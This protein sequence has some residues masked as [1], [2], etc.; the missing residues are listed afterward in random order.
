MKK[1]QSLNLLNRISYLLNICFIAFFLS[2]FFKNNIKEE[3]KSGGKMVN[4]LQQDTFQKKFKVAIVLPT[5]ISA[6][7]TIKEN[8][9]NELNKSNN[10][11]FSFKEYYANN[12]TTLLKSSL[13]DIF[14]GSYDLIFTIGALC[15]RSAREAIKKKH[16]SIPIVFSGVSDAVVEELVVSFKTLIT[17]VKV[18]DV[19]YKDHVALLLQLKKNIKNVV[20][21][22]D[23]TLEGLESHKQ[24][25]QKE[26]ENHGI[27]VTGVPV[28]HTNE[29]VQKISPFLSSTD[30]VITLRDSVVLVGIEGLIKLCNQWGVTLCTSELESVDKGAALG[31]GTFYKDIGIAS[32]LQAK[33]ILIEKTDPKNIPIRS[34]ANTWKMRLNLTTMKQ[35]N[36]SIPKNLLFLMNNAQVI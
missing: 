29:V 14:I 3:N 4:S 6:L 19:R 18:G 32:G 12:S 16:L 30:V 10:T 31:F 20:I 26:L 28:N 33:Q 5:F 13:E 23:N 27:Q 21:L 11:L 25:I 22:Y 35:Q 8:F 34:L 1:I 7:E 15:T 36:L 17:G 24:N 2:L 9:I